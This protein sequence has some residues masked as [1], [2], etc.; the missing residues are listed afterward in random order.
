MSNIKT[1]NDVEALYEK[2]MKLHKNGLY[3]CPVCGK[4][5][6]TKSGADAHIA[7][8]DCYSLQDLYKDT[9]HEV[10]AYAL[11]RE[12]VAELQ[13]KSRVNIA[14]FRKSNMYNPITRFTLFCT[15]HQIFSS[16][17]YVRW[18]NEIKGFEQVNL[19]LSKGIEEP[20]MREF[21]VFL[22]ANDLIPSESF[23]EKHEE[24]LKTDDE[25]LVRSIETSRLGVIWYFKKLGDDLQ[26]RM[27]S[28]PQGYQDRVN[29]V[30]RKINE[31]GVAISAKDKADWTPS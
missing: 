6:K 20:M 22:Q 27:S 31:Y 26:D 28:L 7:K 16:S 9:V 8:R 30:C 25:F 29:A 10:K 17:L 14:S 21:R 15:L 1:I 2:G 23:Y 3:E 12:F 11:Y 13:P 4:T 18:L 24:T 19:I 5:Y